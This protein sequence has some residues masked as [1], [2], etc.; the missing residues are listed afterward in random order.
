[1][2]V[3]RQADRARVVA[4][5][6]RDRLPDP[7]DRVRREAEAPPGVEAR[8]RLGQPEVPLGDEVVEL[9]AGLRLVPARDAEHQAQVPRDELVAARAHARAVRPQ[10]GLA[11][12]VG[13]RGPLPAS[14]RAPQPRAL[15]GAD[16]LEGREPPALAAEAL[17][18]G[19]RQQ[20]FERLAPLAAARERGG[21]ELRRA[22]RPA[23]RHEG[24]ERHDEHQSPGAAQRRRLLRRHAVS[25]QPT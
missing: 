21:V 13:G 9:E 23:R 4:D 22:R 24:G 12:V 15:P 10:R 16:V 19:P 17:L 7:P 14:G 25:S 5:G 3:R 20:R 18:L 6:V 11:R 1:M 8:R 2:H